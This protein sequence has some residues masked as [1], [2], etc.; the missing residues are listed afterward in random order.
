[1]SNKWGDNLVEVSYSYDL[2][3][4]LPESFTSNADATEWLFKSQAGAK[5]SDGPLLTPEDLAEA[6]RRHAHPASHS[7]VV[8]SFKSGGA[9]ETTADSHILRRDAADT[10]LTYLI[11]ARHLPIQLRGA[12]DHLSAA[13][14]T[15]PYRLVEAIAGVLSVLEKIKHDWDETSV[16]MKGRIPRSR[17][18][19]PAHV[20][21]AGVL[22]DMINLVDHKVATM[23]GETPNVNV[24]SSPTRLH[25]AFTAMLDTAP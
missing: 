10:G 3:G 17:L 19:Y 4:R 21:L 15:V 20:S 22:V 12:R 6:L 7:V 5:F 25:Y 24:V 18:Q 1:M 8:P 16:S 9:I 14:S 11:A 13:I 2:I 23:F